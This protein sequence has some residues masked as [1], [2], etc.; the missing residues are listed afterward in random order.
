[1]YAG[2]RSQSLSPQPMSVN[3]SHLRNLN[4]LLLNFFL[5]FSFYPFDSVTRLIIILEKEKF[6]FEAEPEV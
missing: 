3:L 2:G 5:F 6:W 4:F 1:M